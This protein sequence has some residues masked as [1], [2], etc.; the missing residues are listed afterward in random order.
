MLAGI[1]F[2]G[3]GLA[4]AKGLADDCETHDHPLTRVESLPNLERVNAA[5]KRN[6]T[7]EIE[8][9]TWWQSAC[10]HYRT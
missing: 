4:Q 3:S 8:I 10:N 9:D 5:P 7:R 2:A 1:F 6:Q